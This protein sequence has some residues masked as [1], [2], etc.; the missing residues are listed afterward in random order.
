MSKDHAWSTF[1]LPQFGV[2]AASLFVA[3]D[4]SVLISEVTAMESSHN[5][6]L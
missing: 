3:R 6:R 4:L 1:L 5:G 2:V